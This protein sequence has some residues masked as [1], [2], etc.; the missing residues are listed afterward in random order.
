M[1]APIVGSLAGNVLRDFRVSI[2]HK[3]GFVY[4]M[5]SKSSSDTDLTSVGLI[6]ERDS[7]GSLIVTGLSSNASA[8]VKKRT[9]TGDKLM[10]VDDVDVSGK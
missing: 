8:D 10:S 2:D 6:L 4:L 3:N 9:R 7:K 5:P 1:T